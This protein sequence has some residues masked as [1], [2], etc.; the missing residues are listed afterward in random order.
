M[1]AYYLGLGRGH[2]FWNLVVLVWIWWDFATQHSFYAS[3]FV[4]FLF[5]FLFSFLFFRDVYYI[6]I[7]AECQIQRCVHKGSHQLNV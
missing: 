7:E 2:G 1:A 5:A 6:T 4:L 3:I